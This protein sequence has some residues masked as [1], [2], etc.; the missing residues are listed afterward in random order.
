[1]ALD[2]GCKR[3]TV[4][5][6]RSWICL[7]KPMLKVQV[8]RYFRVSVQNLIKHAADGWGSGRLTS[9]FDTLSFYCS[10]TVFSPAVANTSR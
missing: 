9:I 2:Q 3:R 1:V 5:K 6:T 7:I 10:R 4:G 8:T